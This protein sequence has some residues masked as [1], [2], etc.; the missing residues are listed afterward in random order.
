MRLFV[1]CIRL[2]YSLFFCIRYL[3][4]NQAFKI[5]ILISPSVRIGKLYR[6]SI[7]IKGNI[8]R[9]MITI[10]L[11]GS[12]GRGNNRTY[13]SIHKGSH[14]VFNGNATFLKGTNIVIKKGNMMVGNHFLC[15]V[16]CFF[17]C[18]KQIIIGNNVLIG[19]NVSFN[20][21]N[22][23]SIYCDGQK[24]EMESDI[25]IGNHVWICANNEIFKGTSIADGCVVSHHSV[26]SKSIKT[27]NCLIAGNPARIVKE[28]VTWTA[29]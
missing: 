17:N 13:I 9:S 27:P 4:L 8:S 6:S 3:P 7:I 22:G 12:E 15:N 28:K 29:S 18:T 11:P 19:W 5:P 25:Y 21:N 2:I 10:G 23:H 26:L 14:L 16:D 24:K 20:T 1:Y